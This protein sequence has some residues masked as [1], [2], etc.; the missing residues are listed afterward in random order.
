[1]RNVVLGL[2]L[3][4]GASASSA[5]DKPINAVKLMLSRSGS[6]TEKLTFASKDATYLFSGVGSS[7]DP[8][9]SGATITLVSPLESPVTLTIPAGVANPGWRVTNRPTLDTYKYTN[10][11]APAAPSVVR[12][13]KLNE[14]K[15]IK[16][17]ARETGLALT[18][19][20][21]SVGIRITTGTLRSCALFDAATIIVDQPNRFVARGAIATSLANCSDAALGAPPVIPVCGNGVR[22]GNEDCDGTDLPLGTPPGIQCTGTCTF[23]G[24]GECRFPGAIDIPCCQGFGSCIILDANGGV[25][26]GAPSTCGD[27]IVQGAEQCDGTGCCVGSGCET[28]ADGCYPPSDPHECQCCSN[29]QHPCY[30]G[31]QFGPPV[32]CCPGFNCDLQHQNG[33]EA[34]GTCT[35]A[36]CGGLGSICN[37]FPGA[38]PCCAGADCIESAPGSPISVC[39]TP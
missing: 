34:A 35:T 33:T 17:V 5:T 20:Q 12:S 28:Q 9:I 1:M 15:S 31:G 23:C 13:A 14:K 3:L 32:G 18:A 21:G 16:I 10:G 11:P 25:C 29:D 19:A 27:G 7:D 22:E 30:T 36:T 4:A 39:Q 6:G 38:M 26:S 2:L 37:Y 24:T 8:S